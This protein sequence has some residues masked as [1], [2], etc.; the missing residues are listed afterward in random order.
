[1]SKIQSELR[2]WNVSVELNADVFE[3]SDNKL[4]E[5]FMVTI[6][7]D[8]VEDPIRLTIPVDELEDYNIENTIQILKFEL[9]S[10]LDNGNVFFYATS[11]MIH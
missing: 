1:M 9:E 8:L 11:Q 3:G 7:T 2:A 6:F 5:S 10:Y 4:Q